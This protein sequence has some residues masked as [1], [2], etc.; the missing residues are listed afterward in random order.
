MSN[1]AKGPNPSDFNAG[2]TGGPTVCEVVS[3][4]DPEK[5]GR[6]CVRFTGGSE[7]FNTRNTEA[8]WVPISHMMSPNK[9]WGF[10]GLPPGLEVGSKV[11]AQSLGQQSLVVTSVL[12]NTR[13][14][15][16]EKQADQHKQIVDKKAKA[17]TRLPGGQ[18]QRGDRAQGQTLQ[19]SP[20]DDH[21]GHDGKELPLDRIR[22]IINNAV[23]NYTDSFMKR[24]EV[25]PAPKRYYNRSKIR[26]DET[27][28]G[29][30][31]FD[32]GDLKRVENFMR[33]M[34]V[35]FALPQTPT[36]LDF[37]DQV[38]KTGALV[39]AE[40]AVGGMNII[41]QAMSFASSFLNKIKK[42]NEQNQKDPLLEWLYDLYR[43]LKKKEPL[44]ERGRET[45]EYKSWR[46]AYLAGFE[47]GETS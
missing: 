3:I 46:D 34:K 14:P 20:R 19:A 37:L 42:Q 6:V 18:G 29:A 15:E 32:K 13:N 22:Q 36:I 44:D 47:T 23:V 30:F 11:L 38:G 1:R 41:N 27:Q 25:G 17:H 12:P 4:D 40:D 45:Q 5:S 39:K 9:G 7:E 8:V 31:P 26:N 24:V 2:M 16:K 28:I 35:P 10:S 43:E 33:Q 21:R